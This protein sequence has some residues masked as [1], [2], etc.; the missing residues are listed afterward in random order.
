MRAAA[1][2]ASPRAHA[3]ASQPS[4]RAGV[5]AEFSV[6]VGNLDTETS[7]SDLE[8]LLFELF[9]QVYR[10]SAGPKSHLAIAVHK[11]DPNLA[12]QRRAIQSCTCIVRC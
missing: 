7:L 9:L 2:E 1:I 8:E 6:Y 12:S 3:M 4:S 10:V 5:S 11:A